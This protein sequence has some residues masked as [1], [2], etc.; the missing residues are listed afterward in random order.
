[1]ALNKIAVAQGL[2]AIET[3]RT[4]ST[5]VET[6]IHY[7]TNS[8]LIWDCVKEAHQLLKKLST[9]QQIKVRDYRKAVKSNHFKINNTKGDKPVALFKKQLTLFT[10]SIKQVDRFVKKKKKTTAQLRVLA[11]WPLWLIY[12]PH[13][14]SLQHDR[15]QRGQRRGCAK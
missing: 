9:T 11:W 5:V 7:P 15:T 4:D 3:I 6:N 8:A 13:G 14:A 2:E 1:M 10:K 12:T